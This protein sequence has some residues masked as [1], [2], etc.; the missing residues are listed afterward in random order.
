MNKRTF[1]AILLRN[2][3]HDFPKIRKGG[4]MQFGTFPKIH[5]FWCPHLSLLIIFSAE[6]WMNTAYKFVQPLH[7]HMMT[8]LYQEMKRSGYQEI[9]T[10]K[11]MS[12]SGDK[13][14]FPTFSVKPMNNNL[15]C[16]EKTEEG[17][18][19]KDKHDDISVSEDQEIW[20]SECHDISL[21]QEIHIIFPT[22][23]VKPLNKTLSCEEKT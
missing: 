10:P 1:V 20:R 11:C 7:S 13:D 12:P 3:Q 21:H 16:E 22:F 9:R 23:S 14:S 17:P 8:F 18:Q 5:P 4:S 6:S 15:S 19:K 2:P